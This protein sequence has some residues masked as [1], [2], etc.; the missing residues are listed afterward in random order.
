MDINLALS[1]I[2]KAVAEEKSKLDYTLKGA[3]L[4]ADLLKK[5]NETRET[6]NFEYS[7]PG[8]EEARGTGERNAI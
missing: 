7:E 5:G 1:E 4:L 8:L 6:N 3:E 2:R